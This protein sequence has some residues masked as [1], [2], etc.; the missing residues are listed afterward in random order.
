MPSL[1]LPGGAELAFTDS[2]TGPP[3]ILV[4]G[5]PGEGRSWA[6][7]APLLAG[8]YRVVV[9]DLPGYGRSDP[10]PDA[11][12]G[13]T[14]AMGAAIGVLIQSL[15]RD[16]HLCGHSYGANVALHAAVS[17]RSKVGR[18]T[19]LEPV[20]FR[21][22]HLVGD[23]EVL[24]PAVRFFSAYADRVTGGEPEAVCDMID[25]WFGGGAFAKLPA[26]VQG[27][28]KTAAAKNGVDVRAAFSETMTL[29]QLAAFTNPATVAYGATS[30][31]TAPAIAGALVG[32]LPHAQ[33]QVISGAHHG[34]LDTHAQAVADLIRQST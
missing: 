32:L 5:S 13:R 23:K 17:N 25:Y 4:H 2:G 24:E 30:P 33:L 12:T 1:K 9:P 11:A 22:L 31:A 21:A 20:F 28:L 15:G 3:L 26:T 27:F 8:H 34:M 18:L 7:V 29:E 16:V 19:L 14:A 10:L 6:R